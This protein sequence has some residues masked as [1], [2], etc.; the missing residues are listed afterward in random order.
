[1]DFCLQAFYSSKKTIDYFLQHYT[2]REKT[3]IVM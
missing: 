1:M 2:L 3:I